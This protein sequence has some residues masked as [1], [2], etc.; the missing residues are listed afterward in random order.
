M[1][2]MKPSMKSTPHR[3]RRGPRAR[4]ASRARMGVEGAYGF[5]PDEDLDPTASAPSRAWDDGGDRQI[6]AMLSSIKRLVREDLGDDAGGAPPLLELYPADWS[7]EQRAAAERARVEASRPPSVGEA[8]LDADWARGDAL[9]GDIADASVDVDALADALL[10]GARRLSERAPSDEASDP[11]AAW[12]ADPE[13]QTRAGEDLRGAAHAGPDEWGEFADLMRKADLLLGDESP[14][15]LEHGPLEAEPASPRL[16]APADVEETPDDA[17]AEAPGP[18]A[19]RGDAPPLTDLRSMMARLKTTVDFGASYEATPEPETR[20]AEEAEEE[21]EEVAVSDSPADAAPSDDADAARRDAGDAPETAADAALEVETAERSA[22]DMADMADADIEAAEAEEPGEEI[23]DAAEEAAVSEATAET[24]RD[25]A[26]E[27]AE[28]S[29]EEE[30]K[31]PLEEAVE[32]TGEETVEAAP[33]ASQPGRRS[34]DR[35]PVEEIFT[36]PP[37]LAQ[38]DALKAINDLVRRRVEHFVSTGVEPGKLEK[39][40]IREIEAKVGRY[41]PGGVDAL[42]PPTETPRLPSPRAQARASLLGGLNEGY[43]PAPI[44]D[45]EPA[46][47]AAPVD[48]TKASL[49]AW[50][51][52][53]LPRLVEEMVRDQ[54]ERIAKDKSAPDRRSEDGRTDDAAPEDGS[55]AE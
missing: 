36:L 12:P 42:P 39:P 14:D 48:P 52:S 50:L 29:A 22:E 10:Y 43:T 37:T 23:D 31:E 38:K 55:D 41:V 17:T 9:E 30:R 7:L 44:E 8:A 53:N 47:R 21:D 49:T 18:A 15:W 34:W 1:P 35:A 27:P 51:E 13:P 45:P 26:E 16:Q 20:P 28:G 4:A 25:A 3:E 33:S 5:G 54:V 11:G 32:E 6:E 2:E 19:D 40:P 46:P 24:A